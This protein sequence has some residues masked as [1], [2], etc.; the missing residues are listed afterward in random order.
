VG[1]FAEAA[2]LSV[3]VSMEGLDTFIVF[4]AVYRSVDEAEKDYKAV[5]DVYY[6][7]HAM[8]TFDACVITKDEHG[9]VKIVSKHEQPTR[10]GAW[11]GGGLGLSAGVLLALFPA[12]GLGA[13]AVSATGI[14]AGLGAWAGH[15]V[16]GMSR[17]DL[18]DLGEH[19]DE[20]ECALVV[21]AAAA[22][23]DRV[24]RQLERAEKVQR[25]HLE[26]DRKVAEKAAAERAAW[27]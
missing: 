13:A 15:A 21:V 4:A 20:G 16:A 14:G 11:V 18:K 27:A 24:E 5:K 17:S 6:N 12:V 2:V 23:A 9:K 10:Q 3:A 8:D 22:V 1:A 19:L 25:K 7:E 26:A